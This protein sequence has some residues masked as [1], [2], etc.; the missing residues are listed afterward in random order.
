MPVSGY[1][2]EVRR[3]RPPPDGGQASNL[4]AGRLVYRI[5]SRPRM[6]FPWLALRIDARRINAGD[7]SGMDVG[8]RT[9]PEP[10][11]FCRED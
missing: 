7:G 10:S 2:P 8:K 4:P 3:M 9:I 11:A 1:W 6:A 5:R